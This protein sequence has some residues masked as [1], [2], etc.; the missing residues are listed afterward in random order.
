MDK[1]I[2]ICQGFNFSSFVLLMTHQLLSFLFRFAKLFYLFS[3]KK[4]LKNVDLSTHLMFEHPESRYSK[5]F[6]ILLFQVDV[7]KMT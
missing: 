3:G 5:T 7:E 1:S 4:R 6:T 2:L